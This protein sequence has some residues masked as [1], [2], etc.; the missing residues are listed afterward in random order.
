[1]QI[2]TEPLGWSE[3]SREENQEKNLCIMNFST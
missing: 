3:P 2:A 1:M